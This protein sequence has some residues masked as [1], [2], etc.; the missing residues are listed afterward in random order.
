[1]PQVVKA[2]TRQQPRPTVVAG[3]AETGRQRHGRRQRGERRRSG[4][5][6]A[7]A[8]SG[9]LEE[10]AHQQGRQRSPR[11]RAG[12]ISPLRLPR[13]RGDHVSIH[14]HRHALGTEEPSS[15]VGHRAH[16]RGARRRI[17]LRHRWREVPGEPVGSNFRP[18][19]RGLG[20]P[21]RGSSDRAPS[22]VS[23]GHSQ[24]KAGQSRGSKAS[25]PYEPLLSNFR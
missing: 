24:R 10:R 8:R 1:M 7:I 14:T 2:W 18:S 20:V 19:R 9:T 5:R 15:E 25:A 6:S 21:E 16:H 13:P 17:S 22:S 12:G 4:V 23:S 3:R 11:R